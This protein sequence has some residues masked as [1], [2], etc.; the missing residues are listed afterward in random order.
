MKRL[1]FMIIV[2]IL[3][4][5]MTGCWSTSKSGD[6]VP[7]SHFTD[8]DSIV[9]PLGMVKAEWKDWGTWFVF[10]K[11]FNFNEAMSLF[12]QALAQK[13]GADLLINYRIDTTD[14]MYFFV[15]TTKSVVIQGTAADVQTGKL[16]H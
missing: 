5:L 14:S 3:S 12:D 16:S 10:Q 4:H 7:K 11:D 9:K 6:F 2:L 8:P 13:P 1:Y 15:Y